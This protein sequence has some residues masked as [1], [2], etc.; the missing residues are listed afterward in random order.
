M[1]YKVRT[2]SKG[3][4][5]KIK[6]DVVNMDS[7]SMTDTLKNEMVVYDVKGIST[8]NLK[9]QPT[10]KAGYTMKSEDEVDGDI[11]SYQ[12]REASG[13]VAGDVAGTG[14]GGADSEDGSAAGGI[15]GGVVAFFVIG[16]LF[17][18]MYWKYSHRG[19]GED[20]LDQED[21]KG[22]GKHSFPPVASF[23][24]TDGTHV[25][26]GYMMENPASEPAVRRLSL[27]QANFPMSVELTDVVVVDDNKEFLMPKL[28]VLLNDLKLRSFLNSFVLYGIHN[29]EILLNEVSEDD[30]EKMGVRTLQRRR[31]LQKMEE[32]RSLRDGRGGKHAPMPNQRETKKEK[33]INAEP[34]K[35]KWKR[36]FSIATN[37]EYFENLETGTTQWG[38][39]T[40]FGGK[41]E[42]PDDVVASSKDSSELGEVDTAEKTMYEKL[43]DAKL[44]HI[45]GDVESLF[46]NDLSAITD[47]WME[48][49]LK[50]LP[51][52][53]LRTL[54]ARETDNLW[55]SGETA[56]QHWWMNATTDDVLYFP[57]K[58]SSGW[59]KEIDDESGDAYYYNASLEGDEETEE[60]TQW[61][62]PRGYVAPLIAQVP[63][64]YF[65]EDSRMKTKSTATRGKKNWRKAASKMKT[66]GALQRSFQTK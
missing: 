16:G 44:A 15:A 56:G 34:A 20:Y 1:S 19:G 38:A 23:Y 18:F 32:L 3:L 58:S 36:R 55:Y 6:E 65:E 48:R 35:K 41:D 12:D 57:P 24:A 2:M 21:E 64:N 14:G 49:S 62:V 25:P 46:Q 39:P 4:A 53:R 26:N 28:H 42:V 51:R 50:V 27:K 22:D 33:E 17:G 61:E 37:Q 59:M 29:T 63:K 30:L 47:K 52:R 43:S 13:D 54:I 7:A 5:E 40:S 45:A 60:A 31:L 10:G 11:S 9:A 8:D 66:I